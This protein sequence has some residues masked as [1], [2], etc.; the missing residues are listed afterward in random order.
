MSASLVLR[1]VII[2]QSIPMAPIESIYSG[3]PT[4]DRLHNPRNHS[5][6][7]FGS[8]DDFV[9]EA[10]VPKCSCDD[11]FAHGAGERVKVFYLMEGITRP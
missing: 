8:I 6:A 5:H 3:E 10:M 2:W 1:D 4:Y 11:S 9:A 7:A